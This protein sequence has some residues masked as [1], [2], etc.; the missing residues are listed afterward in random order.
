[1]KRAGCILVIA[2]LVIVGCAS[3]G[4]TEYKGSV[5]GGMD[6]TTSYYQ[7]IWAGAKEHKNATSSPKKAEPILVEKSLP[8]VEQAPPSAVSN[9]PATPSEVPVAVT[10]RT[11]PPSATDKSAL[12]PCAGGKCGNWVQQNGKFVWAPNAR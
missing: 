6:T 9:I 7:G 4:K 5:R 2:M 10:L 8:P 11:I 1:M 12:P 3:N